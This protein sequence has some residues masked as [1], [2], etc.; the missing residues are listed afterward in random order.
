MIA[1]LSEARAVVA[2]WLRSLA[3]LLTLRS[4][5]SEDLELTCVISRNAPSR[6]ER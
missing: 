6:H 3:L 5:M 2:P 1:V 4:D